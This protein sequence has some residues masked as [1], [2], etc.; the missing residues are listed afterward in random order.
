LGLKPMG[1]SVRDLA[2]LEAGI[3]AAGVDYLSA[4][5]ATDL[6]SVRTPLE[7]GLSV[8]LEGETGP[9]TG[10]AALKRA[11]ANP[12]RHRLIGLEVAADGPV[13]FSALY[14]GPV[15]VGTAT[16]KGWSPLLARN[17]A[18]ATVSAEGLADNVNLTVHAA[19]SEGVAMRRRQ[20]DVRRLP[21]PF[22]AIDSKS[23]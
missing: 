6:L 23:G 10:Q 9:F 20:L 16:T 7:L 11:C 13:D 12:V 5:R 17:I 8:P 4:H 21:R 2:R 14:A 15:R 22:L 18:L 3:P 1:F 19:V